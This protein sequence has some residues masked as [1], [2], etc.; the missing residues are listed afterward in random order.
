[1][2]F[3]LESISK[4]E[5]TA[6]LHRTFFTSHIPDQDRVQPT[7]RTGRD[8]TEE[9]RDWCWTTEDSVNGPLWED[10]GGF[11][12]LSRELV[13]SERIHLVRGLE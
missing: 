6:T 1:M 3:S 2:N 10:M 7:F 13:K 5:K 4:Y 11:T 9:M 8:S 12:G